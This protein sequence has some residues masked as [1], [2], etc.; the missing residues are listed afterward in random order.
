MKQK[1]KMEYEEALL[2]VFEIEEDIITASDPFED[3][4]GNGWLTPPPSND[5]WG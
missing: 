3:V 1:K 2:E 4:D 5:K